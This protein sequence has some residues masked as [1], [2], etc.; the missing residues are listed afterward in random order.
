MTFKHLFILCPPSSGSTLM[1]K[2]LQTSPLVSAFGWEGQVLAKSQLFSRDRWRAE[3][4]IDWKAVRDRWNQA[5]DM[6]KPV[7]LEK[8]PPHL[9]RA[10][11]LAAQFPNSY[12]IIMIRNPY[13]FC[14]GVK[15][16]WGARKSILAGYSY[17]NLACFWAIC[18][19][20]QIKNQSS[21][22]NALL[23]SYE[24]LTDRPEESS[25][26]LVDFV[27]ELERL[28][29][30][31]E[32]SVFEKTKPVTNLNDKQISRLSDGQLFEIN[33][34]LKSVLG[35]LAH[36]GYS[37]REPR[38]KTSFKTLRKIL[39]RLKSLNGQP[40]EVRWHEWKEKGKD[41]GIAP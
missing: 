9:I 17:F 27:P 28:D 7:L 18:A 5:W 6:S 14:E 11:A 39:C 16:R 34:A 12:F 30:E 2:L 37:L 33:L 1:W 8:S 31:K 36:F 32:I 23:M 15:R 35:T 25:R 38:K 24:E 21:L 29:W 10:G 22:E 13:A 3:K 4:R 19:R 40:P 26:R 41:P 20:Y